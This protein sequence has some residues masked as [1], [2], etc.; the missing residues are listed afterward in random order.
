M[1]SHLISENYN[2]IILDKIE[3]RKD[4]NHEEYVEE[5][6]YYNVY[7]DDCNDDDN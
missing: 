4:L 2:Q 6:K 7:N 1:N 5:K 3:R